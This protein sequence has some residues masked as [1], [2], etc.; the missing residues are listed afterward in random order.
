MEKSNWI[1]AKIE[2]GIYN[3]KTVEVYF[4]KPFKILVDG[5]NISDVLMELH[6]DVTIHGQTLRLKIAELDYSQFKSKEEVV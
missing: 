6:I 2:K 4:G 1:E 5:Q 3:G